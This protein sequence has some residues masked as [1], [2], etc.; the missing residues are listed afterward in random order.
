[1]E[2]LEQWVGFWWLVVT[3]PPLAMALVME[4][5]LDECAPEWEMLAS[6]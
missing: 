3:N 4:W 6:E 1:M 2:L 5:V